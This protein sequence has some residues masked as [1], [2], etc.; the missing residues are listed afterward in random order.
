MDK[1]SPEVKA[2]IL[3]AA[4]QLA[5]AGVQKEKE[6]KPESAQFFTGRDLQD[7]PTLVQQLSAIVSDHVPKFWS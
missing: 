6:G 1:G 5:I 4:M 7:Y 2:G 3:I